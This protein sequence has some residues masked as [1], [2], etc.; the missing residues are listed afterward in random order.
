MPPAATEGWEGCWLESGS[1]WT[2]SCWLPAV[3]YDLVGQGEVEDP[4]VLGAE[5][6]EPPSAPGLAEKTHTRER[7]CRDVQESHPVPAYLP[8]RKGSVHEG[9]SEGLWNDHHGMSWP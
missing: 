2:P 7:R 6:W 9:L 1:R 5:T 4:G 3:W 8:V